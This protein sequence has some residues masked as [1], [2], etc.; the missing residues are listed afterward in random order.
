LVAHG[1]YFSIVDFRANIPATFRSL[2]GIFHCI[3]NVLFIYSTISRAATN[4]DLWE[5]WLENSDLRSRTGDYKF[6]LQFVVLD[7]F[8]EFH[9]SYSFPPD[10]LQG[11][12]W[13]EETE[14]FYFNDVVSY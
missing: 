1:D 5:S 11:V 8:D 9:A 6:Y 13:H 7:Y 14:V 4:D 10:R 2:F 12:E 3:S